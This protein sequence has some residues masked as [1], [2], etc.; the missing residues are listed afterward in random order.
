MS[1]AS[2]LVDLLKRALRDRGETYA[3]LARALR[4]SESSVK[5]L[6]SLR[7]LSLERLEQICTHL[8]MEIHDLLEMARAAEG[9]ITE[10]TE[11]QEEALV[12]DPRL[13]LVGLLALSH[14]SA[15]EIGT[16][17]RLG[18]AEVVKHLT[19]LD[20][21]GII[22]LMPG[23]RIKLRLARDFS[24]RRGGPLQRFFEARVQNEYFDSS[25]RGP[26]E[27]RFVVHGSL[28]PHSNALLQERMKKLVE[29]FDALADEDRRLARAQ[30]W[31]T[32][33]VVAV[34]PWELGIFTALRRKD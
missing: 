18:E 4:V 22:D 23:N 16:T 2:H 21:I 34:R 28:S 27:L 17:Y 3:D 13:L 20:S 19:H 25:F 26:G 1:Q 6:F 14:W 29:E 33:M 15:Q 5:R 7:K 31:G 32:T 30:L 24:W 8:G 11:A 9:R 10:L 12:A